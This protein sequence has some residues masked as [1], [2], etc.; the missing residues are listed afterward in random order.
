VSEHADQFEEREQ[1]GQVDG[2]SDMGSEQQG[3]LSSP[4]GTSGRPSEG[5]DRENHGDSISGETPPS[6]GDL[7]SEEDRK[8][9]TQQGN[10]ESGTNESAAQQGDVAHEG[11]LPTEKVPEAD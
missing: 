5:D 1:E 8:E 2:S 3:G 4:G 10:R 7:P 9:G 11:D 6:R